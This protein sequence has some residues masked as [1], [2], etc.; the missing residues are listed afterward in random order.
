MTGFFI[1]VL[2]VYALLNFYVIRRGWQALAGTRTGR[3]VY[4][5]IALFLVLSFP[6]SRLTARLLP[7]LPTTFLSYLGA[8]F[9]AAVIYAFFFVLL[10]DIVRLLNALFR[11]FP[12]AITENPQ[13]A[14]FLALMAVL[15][16]IVLI[17]AGGFIAAV[18]PRL[19]TLDLTLDKRA[20]TMDRLNLVMIS[21]VHLSSIYRS[22]HLKRIVD[23]INQLKP[24]I[25]LLPGDI[26]DMDVSQAEE[27]KMTITLRDMRA[28]LGV[29]AVTGNHEY[30]GGLARNIEYL[31]QAGVR[32]LQDECLKIDEAFVLAGR[33][34]LSA[35]RFG[36]PR[37]SLDEILQGVDRTLP[38][39]LMDH[40]PFHLE[41]A[42]RS[43]V[44]LQ[45]SGHTHAGQLFPISLINKAMYEQNWGVW[46]R[47]KTQYYI[48]CGVG[49]WGM[50]IRTAGISEIVQIRVTFR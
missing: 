28:P 19:R 33:K 1:T 26:V 39:I 20:G 32:V 25:V 47:G 34:D 5:A 37:K 29:F 22:S 17:L 2:G 43:G 40:E 10:I 11:F 13:R 50:P 41:D 16:A 44:D 30:Y 8:F 23:R 48:S 15:G 24:D 31:R 46:R 21:D 6:V 38:V 27:D 42:E 7:Q 14:G 3:W 49:T 18:Y 45:V 12:R 36:D 9:M 4:L 35:S